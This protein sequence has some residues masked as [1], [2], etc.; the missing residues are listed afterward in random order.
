[1]HK[2]KILFLSDVWL[3]DCGSQQIDNVSNL[4]LCQN[5]LVLYKDESSFVHFYYFS[6]I[7]KMDGGGEVGAEGGTHTLGQSYIIQRVFK[8]YNQKRVQLNFFIKFFG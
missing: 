2:Q 8:I 7:S 5:L 3:F 1:M 4:I 6:F